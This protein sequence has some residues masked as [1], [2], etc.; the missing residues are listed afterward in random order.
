MSSTELAVSTLHVPDALL[1][2]GRDPARAIHFSRDW[3]SD[4]EAILRSADEEPLDWHDAE[5]LLSRVEGLA[6]DAILAG[7]GDLLLGLDVQTAEWLRLSVSIET[8]HGTMRVGL[9]PGAWSWRELRAVWAG[10]SAPREPDGPDPDRAAAIAWKAKE[11]LSEVFPEA[12][13]TGVAPAHDQLCDSCGTPCGSVTIVTESGGAQCSRCRVQMTGEV[14]EHLKKIMASA[15][16][17]K[18]K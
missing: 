14:P 5:R 6:V 11:L 9:G 12:R 15:P 8:A 13:I 17:P 7:R 3:V 4:I 16:K 1:D 2:W 10:A 18:V